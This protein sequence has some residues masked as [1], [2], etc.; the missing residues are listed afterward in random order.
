MKTLF[1][2]GNIYTGNTFAK[3]FLVENGRFR[4]VYTETPELND[5]D[6]K[7]DLQ[8][9]YVYPGFNDSH[10]HLL[11]FGQSRIMAR[12]SE[13][14]SSLKGMMDYL[15][16]YIEKTALSKDTW[17]RGRGWNQDYFEDVKRMP[18]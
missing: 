18:Y 13:H 15:A 3:A 9:K 6:E 7:V 10:M 11:N 8:G 14:T 4:E 12:L 17:I 5:F 16:S 2:N 1:F